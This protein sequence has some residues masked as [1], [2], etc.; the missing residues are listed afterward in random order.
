MKRLPFLALSAAALLGLGAGATGCLGGFAGMDAGGQDGGSGDG[1]AK[2][3]GDLGPAA[4]LTSRER[5][6][7][8]VKPILVTR[9]AS[10]HGKEGSVGPSFMKDPAYDTV[11]GHTG[12][13]V[14]DPTQSKLLT[15]GPHNGAVYFTDAEA[16][17]VLA[18]LALESAKLPPVVSNKP[19]TL[20]V[21]PKPGEN[22]VSLLPLGKEFAGATL[23]FDSSVLGSTLKLSKITVHTDA[24]IGLHIAH[25]L[26]IIWSGG[27]KY[28]DP[29]D[30]FS[31]LDQLFIKDTK[32]QLG[33]GTLL[34]SNVGALDEVAVAF[35]ILEVYGGG[36]PM[37]GGCKSVK[38]FTG[39]TRGTLSMRCVGCHGGGNKTAQAALDMGK[40]NDLS[41]AGQAN[42]CGQI[43]NRV[44]TAAPAMSAIFT[45]T[46][47]K[48]ALNHPYKFGGD[49]AA[50][51][52][53]VQSASQWISKEK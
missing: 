12:M 51:D 39:T 43:R 49:Q 52:G 3:S 1:G 44:N 46:S 23:T 29:V 5:F 9:C 20:P 48:S 8:D 45:V 38:D 18:W 53:F 36:L 13:I 31:N 37:M 24:A 16:A 35:Q 11:M 19:T 40:V 25:P 2:Q 32:T 14:P 42:A 26:F 34:L 28:P 50:F 10:C 21:R 4:P 7:A 30:S 41:D 17:K 6:D 33:P 47:P 22:I 15:K 27:L